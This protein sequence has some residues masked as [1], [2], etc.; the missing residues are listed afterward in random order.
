[1]LR[2]IEWDMT[3]VERHIF[4]RATHSMYFASEDEFSSQVAAIG[5]TARA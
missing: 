5:Q 2:P 4:F 3:E 1:M